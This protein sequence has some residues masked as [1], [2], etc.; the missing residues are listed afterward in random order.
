[1]KLYKNYRFHPFY[2]HPNATNAH[3]QQAFLTASP[4]L[5]LAAQQSGN[6]STTT[7]SISP[8]TNGA[9][10]LFDFTSAA[11]TTYGAHMTG[12]RT[13]PFDNGNH[14]TNSVA[15]A[16]NAN[17]FLSF[18]T[19]NGLANSNA[20][21]QAAINSMLPTINNGYFSLLQPQHLSNA[22]QAQLQDRI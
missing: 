9:N 16:T 8:L 21:N 13:S 6:T 20:N 15:A 11:Q 18:N 3:T 14:L 22:F 1:M 12:A 17:T 4:S 19:N 7:N 5:L 2:Y 10:N